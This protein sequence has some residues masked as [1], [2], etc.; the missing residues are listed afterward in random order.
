[1]LPCIPKIKLK[2]RSMLEKR[3]INNADIVIFFQQLA[4]LFCAGIAI[5]K[6]LETLE[7]N[8]TKLAFRLLIYAVKREILSGK[9]LS[10][11]IQLQ[12]HPFDHLTCQLIKIGERTGKL[13]HTLQKIAKYL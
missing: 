7:R 1:M 12:S 4:T 10:T 6:C 2:I 9:D 13:D 11:S 3:A 5:I 8:Q